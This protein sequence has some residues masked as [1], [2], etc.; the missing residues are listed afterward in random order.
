[1][2]AGATFILLAPPTDF[3]RDQAIARVKQQTGRDL[4]ISGPARLTFYPSIG[5]SLG[6]VSLSAPPDMGGA[7]TVAMEKLDVSVK[8]I[9]L[10][11]R[12]VEVSRLILTRP[13][14]NLQVDQN[15]RKSWDMAS[16]AQAPAAD[17]LLRYAQA[18]TGSILSDGASQPDAAIRLAQGVQTEAG[19][20]GRSERVNRLAA[21]QDLVLD[22][23][24]IVDGAL[25][26]QDAR[27]G[28]R[29]A[30]SAMNV[31]LRAKTLASPLNADGDL[32][33]RGQPVK[34]EG[35]LTTL[36]EVLTDAPAKL[37]LTLT[38]QP[39][40]A[41]YSGSIDMASG[42]SLDGT[43]SAETTSL[44]ALALWAGEASL[45]PN[46]GFGPLSIKGYLKTRPGAFHLNNADIGLD[47]MRITGTLDG[48]T[49]GARPYVKAKLQVSE[50]NL[51][52]YMSDGSDVSNPA[53]NAPAGRAADPSP[54]TPSREDRPNSI[55]D[56]LQRDNGPRV[57]GY[58]ARRGWSDDVINLALL[59][60]TDADLDL[61]VG[62]LLVRD[63]SI[64]RSDL[65]LALKGGIATTTFDRVELYGG[66][67]RGQIS[68]DSRE[69]AATMNANIVVD[70]VS[71]EP[72]LKDAASVDWLSGTGRLT[73]ATTSRGNSQRQLVSALNGQATFEFTDGAVKGFN[74]GKALRGLQQ[75][76]LTGLSATPDEKTD[77]S[78]LSA[79][80]DITNGIASNQDLEMMSPL[81]RVTGQGKVMMPERRVD[82]TLN[83]KLV[84]NL[85]GQGGETGLAGLQ[86]PVRIVG[87]WDRPDIAP[88]LS[89]INAEQAVEA[90]QE[91]GKRFKGK[92]ANE[93]VD[94]LFGKDSK[95]SKKA[96]KFLDGLFR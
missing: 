37:A 47:H 36:A 92:D 60:L 57:K 7:P 30:V 72:L 29:H 12:R 6:D 78:K 74:M 4:V 62:K 50:L 8:L 68:I 45:P 38:A 18:R 91:I 46:E 5:V 22:D 77:F 76:R 14:F 93:V 48:K 23:V 73:L 53:P 44:R 19:S 41:D 86:I 90:V 16:P 83:P 79:S 31:N 17:R 56:L 52:T 65:R 11:S 63:I 26:Y 39:V 49:D 85:S 33:W 61:T 59:N 27:S 35:T 96:K 70:G 24:R 28:T 64:G 2:A 80:F 21:L 15:G 51:N 94:E 81:L 43:I 1:M 42:A 58:K 75:G 3:I 87:P 32:T 9:P 40:K 34:F 54:S 66:N 69:T 25:Q 10:L 84:A 82:Y 55:E 71:A 13:Q 88:D 20:G 95:E 89:K 67:G